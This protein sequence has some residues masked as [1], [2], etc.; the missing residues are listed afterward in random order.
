MNATSLSLRATSL[1]R[2][3][4][5]GGL[6]GAAAAVHGRHV[7]AADEQS[8]NQIARPN[9]LIFGAAAPSTID[10]DTTYRQLYLSQT[11]LMTTD[12][13]LKMSA[14][15]PQ[16]GPKRYETADRMLQFCANDKIG[17]RGH[18]LIWNEWVP[19]WIKSMS[20]EDRR[21]FFDG[22]IEEVVAHYAGKLQ[23]WDIVNEPFWP[24]HKAPGGFRMGPWYDAFGP[25][26]IRRAFER[27]ATVDRTTP[28]VL[29]EAQT[30][31][32]DDLGHTVSS[33]TVLL[34]AFALRPA[35]CLARAQLGRTT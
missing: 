4:V 17:M 6:V 34:L 35:L 10:A 18:C 29:N 8:L 32:D 15:A 13:A 14:I 21:K 7:R 28:F 16:P 12:N 30:E 9:G 19:E 2:R 1:S 27:A 26:Y 22:Y 31:R 25:D 33:W 3:K 23:S 11:G 20:I 24:G 5:L